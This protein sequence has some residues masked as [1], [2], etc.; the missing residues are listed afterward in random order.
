ME[1]KKNSSNGANKETGDNNSV[2][3][4]VNGSP[5]SKSKKDTDIRKPADSKNQ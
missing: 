2:L 1:N 3:K 4:K 5:K